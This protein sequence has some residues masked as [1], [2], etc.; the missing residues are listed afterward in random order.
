M[1]ER[2]HYEVLQIHPSADH[3][4][5]VQAY[6]HLARKY[7]LAMDRDM[8]AERALQEL[9]ESFEVL[10]SP[11]R[12]AEYDCACAARRQALAE[13]PAVKR[14]SI[15]VAFWHLPAWQGMVAAAAGLA[16]AVLAL[17]ADA[18][19][20]AVAPLAVVVVAAAL[21]ALPE[22]LFALGSGR[23]VHFRRRGK[24]GP[25]ALEVEKATSKF[26]VRWR[27]GDAARS[28]SEY[29]QDR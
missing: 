5:V 17:A 4:M 19:P 6:W 9:N 14:V 3:A 12:R 24:R 7:K 13:E 26:V 2:D 21:L 25:R 8:Y 28:W 29:R 15:E 20:V 27:Q 11:E 22:R 23:S 10:S 18:P 16:L 1:G